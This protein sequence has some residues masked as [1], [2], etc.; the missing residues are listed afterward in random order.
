MQPGLIWKLWQQVPHL[1][2][3]VGTPGLRVR[4]MSAVPSSLMKT[5]YK[6]K[7]QSRR[8][9]VSVTLSALHVQGLC[10][11]TRQV[12]FLTGIPGCNQ[13]HLLAQIG[14]PSA[15]CSKH[16]WSKQSSRQRNLD[17]TA[18]LGAASF[19]L[20]AQKLWL[21]MRNRPTTIRRYLKVTAES[22]R[23]SEISE[24]NVPV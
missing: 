23:G 12:K 8:C 5:R 18:S 19:C 11:Q 15:G 7:A 9:R 17:C 6:R 21:P 3:W 10:T 13:I 20:V 16:P 4:G 24:W 22:H 2:S 14:L 1:A